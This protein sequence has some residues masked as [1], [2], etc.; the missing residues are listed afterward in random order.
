MPK[1]FQR[2]CILASALVL[3]AAPPGRGVGGE[4]LACS[5]CVPEGECAPSAAPPG[6]DCGCSV[7]IK[8]G[9]S[10][11]RPVS[12]CAAPESTACTGD[13][14]LPLVGGFM[15]PTID[16]APRALDH[17]LTLVDRDC[18]F[19]LW[20]AVDVDYDGSGGVRGYHFTTGQTTGTFGNRQIPGDAHQFRVDVADL[21]GD[22]CEVK[23]TVED[24]DGHV[25]QALA[26]RL[27]NRG[28]A[29]ELHSAAPR[30]EADARPVVWN[31]SPE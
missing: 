13:G 7:R 15:T 8:D 10:I 11:C 2:A 31:L 9:T 21:G 24:P 4:T 28:L 25:T 30:A 3:T 16:I 19:A 26:G 5:R 18:G 17:L 1:Q 29:G 27:S 12:S 23:V 14:P 22:V 20:G 6:A